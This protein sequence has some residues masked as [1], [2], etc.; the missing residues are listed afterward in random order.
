M[1]IF[2]T[3]VQKKKKILYTLNFAI[4]RPISSSLKYNV[5]GFKFRISNFL[6]LFSVTYVTVVIV[7]EKL[8]K[9]TFFK[10]VL[11][12]VNCFWEL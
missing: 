1:T 3:A 12:L 4:L 10:K 2:E 7:F 11:L 9:S 6:Q 5:H 8:R